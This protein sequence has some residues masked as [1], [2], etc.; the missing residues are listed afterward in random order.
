MRD[1]I[2]QRD[3]LK[4]F[5]PHQYIK[6]GFVWLGIIFAHRYD[7]VTLAHVALAFL[8]FCAAASSVYVANDILDIESDRLH[9]IK[10]NRPIARGAL[11]VQSGWILS[12]FL[13]IGA[14]AI[15]YPVGQA[16]ML[17]IAGYLIIN[18][19]YSLQLKHVV[20][21]D[22]FIISAGFMLRIMA[23]TVAVDITPSRWL[24]LTGLM[25]TLFLGFAKRRAELVTLENAGITDSTSVRRVLDDYSDVVLDQL[26][27]ITAACTVLSYGL[28]TVSPETARMQGTHALFY[29]LPFVIYGIFRYLFLLHHRSRGSDTAKDLVTDKHMIVTVLGWLIVTLVVLA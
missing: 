4:L 22:V 25:I 18:L 12:G 27:S 3:I 7:Y 20:I 10:R 1:S 29:T 5:R 8:A 11:S 2:R 14:L 28:Y 23:G 16:A 17:I 6:N 13:G 19:A 21:L 9:P 24:L 26:I 15:S